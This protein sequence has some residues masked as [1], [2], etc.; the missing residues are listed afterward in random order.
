MKYVIGI[1]LGTSGTKTALFDQNGKVIASATQEYPL[2]QPQNGWAEQDPADWWNACVATVG[3]VLT[4]SGIPAANIAGIGL[5]GQMH[6]LVMLDEQGQVL[7]NSILWCD[8]RTGRECEEITQLVGVERLIEL[9]ANPALTGFTAGKILWVRRHEPELYARCHQMMLPKDYL[10]YKLTGVYA[11]E[12]SDASGTNLLD[13][14]NRCWSAEVLEKLSI[15]P[16]LLPPIY[17]SCAVTGQVTHEAAALTGLAAGTLVVGGAADNAAAAV[18]TG[19]VRTGR[20]FTTIGTSGV[21]FAHADTVSI[22]RKGRVHTFCS[23]VP[24]AWTVMSC[25]LSAGGS[26]QWFRNQLC[27]AEMQAARAQ[28]VDPYELMSADAEKSP[29]GANRLLFL[30]YLMGERSPILDADA[31][32]VFFGLSG[33]HAKRDMTR[34][35]MEGVTYSLRQCLDV[36]QEMGIAFETMLATGGGAKSPFWRQMMADLYRCEV[37]TIDSEEGP[38]LG[39]AILAAVGAGLYPDV[40]TACDAIITTNPP[41]QPNAAHTAQ[42]EPYYARYTALYPALKEQFS[43]LAALATD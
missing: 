19:V 37:T 13:V 7:R 24:G 9:T 26:L 30:P 23:A 10:R 25:T 1:D 6:G 18:G 43:A 8:G 32:G 27:E 11:T 21:I 38:A 2:H 15:D 31:R 28:G 33:I 14:P 4:Q 20:A 41:Q 40:E 36:L 42:Y 5:S 29:I 16:S 12:V 39:A 22:D 3:Q 17:E 34:A 35:V